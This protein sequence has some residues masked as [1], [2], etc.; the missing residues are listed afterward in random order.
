MD[1][2]FLK[3]LQKNWIQ[4]KNKKIPSGNFN[5][6]GTDV[7]AFCDSMSPYISRFIP[8]NIDFSFDINKI[9][10]K[11]QHI[12]LFTKCNNDDQINLFYNNI[13]FLTGIDNINKNPFYTGNTYCDT[14][15]CYEDPMYDCKTCNKYLC[16]FCTKEDNF[17]CLNNKHN[18]KLFFIDSRFCNICNDHTITGYIFHCYDHDANF[19]LCYTCSKKYFKTDVDNNTENFILN[20]DLIDFNRLQNEQENVKD[21]DKNMFGF[22]YKKEYKPLINAF[23]YV[24]IIT[25]L[26]NDQYGYAVIAYNINKDSLLFGKILY[27]E[28]QPEGSVYAKHTTKTIDE[29]I[30]ELNILSDKCVNVKEYL[31]LDPLKLIEISPENRINF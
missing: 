11:I 26:N 13:L 23:D 12:H 31:D 30:Y 17:S 8:T 4:Y 16:Y 25:T 7:D 21:V 19:D 28:D 22:A 24:P 10:N 27:L 15:E 20:I 29:F 3:I 18:V 2:E 5:G 14:N 9:Y 1:E 6:Y